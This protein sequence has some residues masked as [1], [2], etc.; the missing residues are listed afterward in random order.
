MDVAIVG[1]G[2]AGARAAYVLARAGARVTIFDPSH[3]REKPCGGGV[4]GRALALVTDAI[5]ADTFPRTTIRAMRFTSSSEAGAA[6]GIAVTLDRGALVVASRASFDAA[7]LASAE[8]A[9]ASV[10]RVRVRD[11]AV[12]RHAVRVETARGTR[13]AAFLIGADGANSLVRRRLAGA[14]PRA[15][16]SIAT[17]Y[18]AHGITS[19]EAV[20]ELAANPPGYMW[21]FPRPD[22]LAIGICAQADAG[23]T[24]EELRRR[25]FAWIRR[26]HVAGDARL[27]P[28][29]W[30]I[31]SLRPAD[32]EALRLA[33]SRWCLAG[34]AA[35]LVDPITREGIF[36]A[37]A[38]GEWAA[39]A[40]LGDGGTDR[41]AACV[42]DAV[43]PELRRAAQVKAT[44]FAPAF[45]RL[46]LEAL[47]ESARIR[48]VMAD[49]I[50]GRQTY[51]TL[52]WRLLKTL[53]V[54]VAW[55]ALH[56]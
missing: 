23:A 44:F 47:Q 41:Y 24:A 11:V 52:K 43:V 9:G 20:I 14:F 10:E 16:L 40:A 42:R 6:D 3:P 34:D 56:G 12:D 17:G 32:L 35:G 38:S 51:S 15:Q 4:T 8:R 30:P 31:P 18:F 19:H 29:S 55:R 53:E 5:G 39:E 21:S 46:L 33:G 7:L 48:A 27:E 36:F 13:H 26:T 45:T 37:L 25:T 54:R 49:L 28:Y 2:P 1:A 50:T 22:H